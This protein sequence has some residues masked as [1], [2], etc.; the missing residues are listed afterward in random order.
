MRFYRPQS[1]ISLLL[2][3]FLFV[4]L[5][6]LTALYSSVQV[7]DGLVQQ[8]VTAV[9]SSV[10][11]VAKSRELVELLQ[12]QERMARMYN[13]LGESE[14][15]KNVNAAH[16][17]IDDTL[18]SFQL[19]N[20]N[21][22]LSLLIEELE[23]KENYINAVLNRFTSDP[24]QLRSEKQNVLSL[25][26]EIADLSQKL[27]KLSGRIT[28]DEVERLR[29][30]VD[31]DK[32]QLVWQTSVL[33]IFAIFAGIVFIL[34]ILK[35]I[36]QIDKGIENLGDGNFQ[37]PI[38]V[39]GPRD[40]QNL[41]NKL[42]W[43]RKR[44][45]KLDREKVKLIA[46]ISHDLKTPLASITEGAGLLRD[47]L[48]GP[49]NSRQME[50]VGILE[51]NC[52]KLQ[53]LIE[54]ILNFNMAKAKE[55]PLQK[56]PIHLEELI[57]EVV[58]DHRN[59]TMARSIQLDVKLV[60]V[61]MY[62]NRQQ[63]KTVFDNLLSNAV[64]FTPD[65]GFIR[66]RL[67]KDEYMASCY[68][69]DSGSGIDEEERAQIF[70]PFF[71]G[72]RAEKSLIKGSGLGLAISKEYVQNHRGTIRLLPSKRGARF[73]VILPLKERRAVL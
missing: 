32:K 43:L 35:P 53:K 44:L 14:H 22:E 63:L 61:A 9:Y 48:V 49:I 42:D 67:K 38:I 54:N 66:I 33:I 15:L 25:Y 16:Q 4:C 13:V 45:A 51:K 19:Y 21:K 47:Q 56:D 31:Q 37:T 5:P 50:V 58:A 40:L 64:K 62:G 59:T 2:L 55:F 71:K 3:A 11:R 34:L 46:H 41:G 18:D 72:K 65:G 23:S 68:V 17:F 10:E 8:S 12:D 28:M 20:G 70:S 39:S 60:S 69:A 73:E 36:R 27:Q 7:L 26:Q 57:D 30:K 24:E 1:F 29:Q 52:L 6:L